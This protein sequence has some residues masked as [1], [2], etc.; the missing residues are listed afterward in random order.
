MYR[1]AGHSRRTT[2]R[3][4]LSSPTY[5]DR[6][7]SKPGGRPLRPNERPAPPVRS[8][9]DRVRVAV[10]TAIFVSRGLTRRDVTS[11]EPHPP[12]SSSSSPIAAR[13]WSSRST[14]A[15][16]TEDHRPADLA[17][18]PRRPADPQR[19]L[20]QPNQFGYVDHPSEITDN[21][22]RGA[23][24]FILPP[25]REIA[26]PAE[27]TLLPATA[28]EPQNLDIKRREVMVDGGFKPT[29]RRAAC[30]QAKG[31]LQPVLHRCRNRGE[32]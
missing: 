5:S 24:G 9:A 30:T 32:A 4:A 22:R 1:F 27:D 25:V 3:R 8:D 6:D 19:K 2:R 10:Q 20:S 26:N 21:T 17:V 23:R 12:A 11:L 14:S 18:G 16:T 13:K 7:A 29:P 28:A 31:D 15:S